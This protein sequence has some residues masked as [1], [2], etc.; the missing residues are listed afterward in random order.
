MRTAVHVLGR[1]REVS[2][3]A[4]SSGTSLL[5]VSF[6]F[7]VSVARVFFLRFGLSFFHL[8]TEEGY[9]FRRF[10]RFVARLLRGS[11]FC[12]L[13]QSNLELSDRG[14][15]VVYIFLPFPVCKIDSRFSR[16]QRVLMCAALAF[17]S[18]FP[19]RCRSLESG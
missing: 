14:G 11:L 1:G 7:K 5:S 19:L 10:I 12:F 2:E 13:Y 4:E 6:F 9:I 3:V 17:S 15:F 8:C 16:I 18:T